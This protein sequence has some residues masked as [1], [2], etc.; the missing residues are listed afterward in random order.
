MAVISRLALKGEGGGKWLKR[1]VKVDRISTPQD[2]TMGWRLIT[3][4]KNNT[5]I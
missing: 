3:D 2:S 4:G 5:L 1:R